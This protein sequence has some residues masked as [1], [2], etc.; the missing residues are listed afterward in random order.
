MKNLTIAS[1]LTD[2][3]F[4]ITP[5]SFKMVAPA[6]KNFGPNKQILIKPKMSGFLEKDLMSSRQK[7]VSSLIILTP[8]LL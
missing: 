4:G 2:F 7:P 6:T 5:S 8:D 3:F 1:K